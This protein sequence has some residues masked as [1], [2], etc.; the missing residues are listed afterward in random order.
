MESCVRER[1]KSNFEE[2][3]FLYLFSSFS[4]FRLQLFFISLL[5]SLFVIFV[6]SLSRLC[7]VSSF[8]RNFLRLRPT[9]VKSISIITYLRSWSRFQ[10]HLTSSSIPPPFCIIIAPPAELSPLLPSIAVS[11]YLALSPPYGILVV[12]LS[13]VVGLTDRRLF[14]SPP[15]SPPLFS[16]FFFI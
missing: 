5:S 9:F 7:L 4:S 10:T 14:L 6:I 13:L 12:L 1:S 2:F 16:F 11:Y 8:L 3:F 15:P